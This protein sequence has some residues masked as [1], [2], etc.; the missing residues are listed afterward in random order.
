MTTNNQSSAAASAEPEPAQRLA[1]AIDSLHPSTHNIVL[2]R[3]LS[4]IMVMPPRATSDGDAT[5]VD[6]VG[7]WFRNYTLHKVPGE[8]PSLT[9]D[10]IGPLEAIAALLGVALSGHPQEFKRAIVTTSE[11]AARKLAAIAERAIRK[12]QV[13]DSLGL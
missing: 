1:Q 3:W 7:P 13:H 6:I 5:V 12:G 10:R 4:S 2:G 8:S 11:R 9:N